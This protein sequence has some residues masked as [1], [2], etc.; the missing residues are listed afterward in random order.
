VLD[1]PKIHCTALLTVLSPSPWDGHYLDKHPLC[2]RLLL[3]AFCHLMTGDSQLLHAQDPPSSSMKPIQPPLG[4]EAFWA[5]T[6]LHRSQL[7]GPTG[8]PAVVSRR[9]QSHISHGS[10]MYLWACPSLAPED[11][12]GGSSA[13]WE[14]R[15]VKPLPISQVTVQSRGHSM[16]PVTLGLLGSLG[17]HSNWGRGDQSPYSSGTTLPALG[18]PIPMKCQPST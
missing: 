12:K 4:S 8:H 3:G 1:S 18:G 7:S 14:L 9:R 2:A 10:S 17:I 11:S 13:L 15:T 5:S 16:S 6:A